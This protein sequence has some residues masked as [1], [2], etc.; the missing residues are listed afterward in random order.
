MDDVEVVKPGAH[1]Q[2][3]RR[4]VRRLNPHEQAVRRVHVDFD[5]QRGVLGVLGDELVAEDFGPDAIVVGGEG[6]VPIPVLE[7]RVGKTVR[8]GRHRRVGAVGDRVVYD[9]GTGFSHV[10]RVG[11]GGLPVDDHFAA[12]VADVGK[13]DVVQENALHFQHF[14]RGQTAGRVV[15]LD[16]VVVEVVPENEP[17]PVPF[18]GSRIDRLLRV[19]AQSLVEVGGEAHRYVR[20]SQHLQG[21]LAPVDTL[22]RAADADVA[23]G[24]IRAIAQLQQRPGVDHQRRRP[25]HFQGR[26][27]VERIA[28]RIAPDLVGNVVQIAGRIVRIVVLIVVTHHSYDQVLIRIGRHPRPGVRQGDVDRQVGSFQRTVAPGGINV[29]VKLV[30]VVDV[31]RVRF[32]LDVEPEVVDAAGHSVGVAVKPNVVV[33]VDQVRRAV[34]DERVRVVR[35]DAFGREVQPQIVTPLG[36]AADTRVVDIGVVHVVAAGRHADVVRAGLQVHLEVGVLAVVIVVL[37]DRLISDDSVPGLLV[38]DYRGVEQAR[39]VHA[40]GEDLGAEYAVHVHGQFE[41]VHVDVDTLGTVEVPP[42]HDVVIARVSRVGRAGVVLNVLVSPHDRPDRQVVRVPEPEVV[43]DLVH[44]HGEEPAAVVEPIAEEIL[45]I[46]QG[47][48]VP[49]NSGC[50]VSNPRHLP[51]ARLQAHGDQVAHRH[52]NPQTLRFVELH[53]EVVAE[54]LEDLADAVLLRFSNQQVVKR[55]ALRIVPVHVGEVV[56]NGR[57]AVDRI[58]VDVRDIAAQ[59]VREVI[60]GGDAFV[61]RQ[62][63]VAGL[64]DGPRPLQAVGL[65]VDARR[66]DQALRRVA[67]SETT[68]PLRLVERVARVDR[69]RQDHRVV[70]GDLVVQIDQRDV[71]RVETLVVGVRAGGRRRDRPE[72]DVAVVLR[73]VDT[74]HGHGL[75]HVPVDRRK[76]EDR[77]PDRPLGRVAGGNLNRDV[78]RRLRVQHDREHG[79][80]AT[81]RGLQAGDRRDRDP[82]RIVVDIGHRDVG[83]GHPLVERIGGGRIGLED[84]RVD[85]VVV[86]K[87]VVLAAYVH[88]LRL[89]PVRVGEIHGVP[90]RPVVGQR[91]TGN[92][93]F[94]QVAGPHANA[95][96]RAGLGREI[97]HHAEHGLLAR[98][99]RHQA[100][101]GLN[102]DSGDVVIL[103]DDRHVHGVDAVVQRI[104]ALRRAE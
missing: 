38:Q 74:R 91:R 103:I 104:V 19:D 102:R 95:D 52:L 68:Q 87:V 55:L 90:Q 27:V 85:L 65:R 34:A 56:R 77:R 93:P 48:S 59:E 79:R 100:R 43:H 54:Q 83:D 75:G 46:H 97:E 67:G 84:N 8:V 18:L 99:R 39:I 4:A 71:R 32:R 42:M 36:N 1:L 22:R 2:L 26:P 60:F 53:P 76:R 94:G 41:L 92:G 88:E 15:V 28:E 12:A 11:H 73:I 62:V 45:V 49:S 14:S 23:F 7:L 31:D 35:I 86:I 57:D 30:D 6:L 80:P 33:G 10:N 72:A 40:L 13:S 61:P 29:L 89:V 50:L 25:G 63:A 58:G 96:R 5:G 70:H 78:R 98:L 51:G 20:G 17:A 64:V 24:Q 69:K 81:L 101:D 44:C 3:N 9:G 47:Q 16:E 37:G 82:R 66:D 21:A